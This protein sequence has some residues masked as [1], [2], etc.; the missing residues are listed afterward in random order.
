M[1]ALAYFLVI[2]FFI[3]GLTS[4]Y[5]GVKKKGRGIFLICLYVFF[6]IYTAAVGV[7][8]AH[9]VPDSSPDESA[10]IAYVYYLRETG[11]I[12][13]HFE[14]MH[15]FNNVVMKW[16]EEPN[17]EY[18]TS[19]VN[20]LCHPPLY[21]HIMRLAGGF[22]P[23]ESDVV[24]TIHK[25]QLRYFSM[26]IA[27]IG[28]G[29]ML[30]IGYSRLPKQR[31]WLHLI[32]A[33]TVT[34]IPMLAYE[35]CAVT[36]DALAL[37]TSAICILGLIRFCEG[38]RNVGTY[39]LIAAGISASLLTK[40]TAAMLCIFMA[41]IV[42]I[43]SMIKERSLKSLICKEFLFSIPVYAIAAIYYVLVYQRY[44]TIHP[45]LELI[46]SKEYF[47]N[48][49][50]YVS[51]AHRVSYSFN[52]YLSY[53]FE[54]FFLS[55]S[56]IESIHRFMKTYTYSLTAIPF[57]L[58]WV[59][60]V[61]VF[62][63]IVRKKADALSLPIL[64]GW[65]S[66]VLTFIYQLKSAYGTYIT[67]GYLGGFASRYY[68]PFIPILALS[69]ALIFVSLLIENGFNADT[70]EIKVNGTIATFGKR[71]LY[72]HLIYLSGLGYAALLFYGNFPFFLLHFAS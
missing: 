11:E 51:E 46:C 22:A 54:R 63:P 47:E 29:I 24:M 26:G 19:L 4:F 9:Y 37:V 72:N 49:I 2:L 58:L 57:E 13:P 69:L 10:H 65:I 34:N 35:L 25:M 61:L 39:M 60:P 40:L 52:E 43:V 53:Y 30:Y 48:T 17:Y 7:F 59:L 44:G 50:Y 23:T 28:I 70:E 15:I 33:V 42:L 20:Y 6:L 5:F 32:Y 18:Q 14:N 66:C 8:Y 16:S 36:N 62:A 3:I 55:W 56:G 21:Y 31:P 38:K 41:L 45:S 68:L 1:R 67:R 71:M 12:I 27:L 64:A